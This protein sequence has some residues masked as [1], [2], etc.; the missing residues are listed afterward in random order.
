MTGVAIIHSTTIV[1]ITAVATAIATSL[2]HVDSDPLCSTIPSELIREAN[3]RISVWHKFT[4]CSGSL[5]VCQ[6]ISYL[7]NDIFFAYSQCVR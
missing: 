3:Q 2:V 5:R 1:T 4:T 6:L 7:F